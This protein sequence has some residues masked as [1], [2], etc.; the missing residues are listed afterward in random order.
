MMMV[1]SKSQTKI[2]SILLSGS[3]ESCWVLFR[4]RL[5]F[6]FDD[7]EEILLSVFIDGV[8]E[9]EELRFDRSEGKKKI[10]QL[11][12][13]DVFSFVPKAEDERGSF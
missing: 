13:S 9:L 12:L 6:A 3:G 11:L 4:V 5:A 10:V 2:R 7:D 1:S 8:G